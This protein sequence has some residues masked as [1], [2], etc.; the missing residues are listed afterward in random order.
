MSEEQRRFGMMRCYTK[1]ISFE[2][3]KAPQIFRK[4]FHPELKMN[5]NTNATKLDE[6][7]YE[8]SVEVTIE[9]KLKDSSEVA[10]IVEIEQAGL[11]Q[12]EGFDEQQLSHLLG[13]ACPINLFPYLRQAVDSQ[14]QLGSLPPLLLQPIDFESIW[15]K[16]QENNQN[17]QNNS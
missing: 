15:R 17:N 7:V 16:S 9:A 10:F 13:V 3:P 2:M 12:V 1:D 11:F 6:N 5:I 8:S 14:L 4:D